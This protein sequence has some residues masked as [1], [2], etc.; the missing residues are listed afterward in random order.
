METY[1]FRL[2]WQWRELPNSDGT[3][4]RGRGSLV[5]GAHV[6]Q[7]TG[8]EA[9]GGG[10]NWSGVDPLLSLQPRL[11]H[12]LHCSLSSS[13]VRPTSGLACVPNS[14]RSLPPWLGSE[15]WASGSGLYRLGTLHT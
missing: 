2:V 5:V 13:H 7:P 11:P 3:F 9:G 4:P 12:G 1:F 15:L 14:S 10:G 6:A 8:R